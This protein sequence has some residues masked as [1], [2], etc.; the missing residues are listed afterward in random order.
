MAV[1]TLFGQTGG[2]ALVSDISDYTFGMQF[3]LSQ[4]AS[5]TGIWFYSASGAASLPAA[6]CIYTVTGAAQVVGTV[7]NSPTWSGAAASGWVKCTYNGSVTLNASTNYKVCVYDPGGSNQ[8][9]ATAHYWDSGAG[10]GGLTS[11][12]ITAPN[13]AGADHGQDSFVNPS[14]GLVYPNASFNAG[15]YWVDVEVT[16]ASAAL[17][18]P[19]VSQYSGLY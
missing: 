13:N 6:C 2:G 3:T 12:I 8:Y 15:N 11:G 7:N 19:L 1:Y 5:L 14:G 10:S 4:S 17:P 16:T 18:P 9:S